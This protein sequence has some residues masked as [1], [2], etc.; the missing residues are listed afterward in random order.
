[1]QVCRA[2]PT[3]A[4]LTSNEELITTSDK[5]QRELTGKRCYIYTPRDNRAIRVERRGKRGQLRW[6][7]LGSRR[8]CLGLKF[9]PMMDGGRARRVATQP[10]N[11][12]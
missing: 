11:H 1:M 2:I 5:N 7:A 10:V 6:L 3:Q 9:S 4:G 12:S 8:F